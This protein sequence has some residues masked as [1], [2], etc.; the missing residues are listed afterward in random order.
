MSRPMRASVSLKADL[1]RSACRMMMNR[2]WRVSFSLLRSRR[3]RRAERRS[4]NLSLDT[5]SRTL[6]LARATFLPPRSINI[7]HQ[8]RDATARVCAQQQ[9]EAQA[10]CRVTSDTLAQWFFSP[11]AYE[12]TITAIGHDSCVLSCL[13]CM[14]YNC[15]AYSLANGGLVLIRSPGV[16]MKL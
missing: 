11:F 5:E 12:K 7:S 1:S 8:G 13:G 10:D 9:M 4:R 14:T 6:P 2:T 3:R 16:R 15:P